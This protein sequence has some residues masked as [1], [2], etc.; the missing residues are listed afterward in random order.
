LCA[1]NLFSVNLAVLKFTSQKEKKPAVN[2]SCIVSYLC[3]N[4]DGEFTVQFAL[5][6]DF[7]KKLKKCY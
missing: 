2:V 5:V 1:I 3:D 6:F 4:F 7:L